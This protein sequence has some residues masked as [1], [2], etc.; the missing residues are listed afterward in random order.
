MGLCKADDVV[1]RQEIA[2]ITQFG[3]QAEFMGDLTGDFFNR[4]VWPAPADTRIDQL[5]KILCG[6]EIIRNLF[7]GVVITQ[8]IQ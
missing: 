6:T 4:S 8:F 7:A 2:L 3:N 5:A 1:D